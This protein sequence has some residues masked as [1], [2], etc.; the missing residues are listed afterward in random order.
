MYSLFGRHI[1][2]FL[3]MPI[4]FNIIHT[5]VSIHNTKAYSMLGDSHKYFHLAA[6]IVFFFTF[7]IPY[8][9]FDWKTNGQKLHSVCMHMYVWTYIHTVQPISIHANISAYIHQSTHGDIVAKWIAYGTLDMQVMG[10][11]LSAAVGWLCNILRQYVN[12]KCASPHSGV[13]EY[14]SCHDTKGK[15]GQAS[16]WVCWL[17]LESSHQGWV[18]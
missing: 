16:P 12:S 10:L 13:N 4:N 1:S 8:V 7:V 18:E 2:S 14:Q 9:F 3:F 15:T 11:N 17:L 5:C 6:I